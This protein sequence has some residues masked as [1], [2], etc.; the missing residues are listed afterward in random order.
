MR[1]SRPWWTRVVALVAALSVPTAARADDWLGPDKAL[2]ATVSAALSLGGQ[3]AAISF[4]E[5]APERALFG[6]FTSLSL[7]VGKELVD[8]LG[9][10]SASLKDL[11]WDF[12]G[13]AAGALLGWVIDT[14]LVTP[15]L[16]SAAPRLGF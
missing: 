1:A 14:W 3:A 16:E 15:L 11:T 8:G 7:G 6:F 2:H 13:A 9:L 5:T 10:G 4:L 12:V